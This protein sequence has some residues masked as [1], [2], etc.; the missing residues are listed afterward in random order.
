MAKGYGAKQ[1]RVLEGLEGVRKRPAMYIGSTGPKGLHHLVYEVVDNSVDEAMAGYCDKISVTINMD[2]SVTVVDNGRG[3]PADLH[4]KE[5]VSAAEVVMTKLH[6]GGKFDKGVYKVSGGLHGVGVSVVNAVSEWL[7]L[8]TRWDGDV[9]QQRYERGVPKGKLKKVGSSKA[10]G[11]KITFYPD[12]EIFPAVDFDFNTL[13]ARMRELAYLNRG[14]KIAVTDERAE[15]E[16]IFE[17]KGGIVAFV[18]DL[19]RGSVTLHPKPI[20]LEGE[21]DGVIIEI[22][23]Q[24]ND[25]YG[26]RSFSFVNNI[27]TIEGG[28]HVSG[29]RSSLTRTTNAYG[30]ANNLFKNGEL[31]SGDD[32]REGLTIVISAK[33]PEP[34]FEGQTKTK[35]GNGEVQGIVEQIVNDKLGAYLEQHPAVAK[36]VVEKAVL[37]A[38]A[39]EAARKARDLTRRKGALDSGNLPGKL[40]DCSERDPSRCE[41]YLVEGDSA[42]GSAKQPSPAGQDSQC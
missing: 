40:A 7:E 35:L 34:Q 2:G 32:I 20:Y 26:E 18:E 11:T 30:R 41:I 37:A 10:S 28:T 17:F 14:L 24:Y 29:L 19:N 3:I 1:I 33:V 42:G 5:K 25:G 27:N 39:R 31:P 23:L 22:A 15:K 38:R 36:K 13:C 9:Y 8:E 16:E 12:I 21:R 4:A 6:A